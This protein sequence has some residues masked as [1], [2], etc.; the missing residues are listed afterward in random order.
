[1]SL[2]STTCSVPAV[3]SAVSGKMRMKK[4]K[5][6]IIPSLFNTFKFLFS[7]LLTQSQHPP[8]HHNHLRL[9]C[10]GTKKNPPSS[11]F[12][13]LITAEQTACLSQG[14][15]AII[16]SHYYISARSRC[17]SLEAPGHVMELWST[18]SGPIQINWSVCFFGQII[19]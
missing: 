3:A 1:M 18:N 7:G 14:L 6:K 19:N 9:L 15:A 12:R 11:S 10:A 16:F 2:L 4:T 13:G 17:S 5:S 8:L